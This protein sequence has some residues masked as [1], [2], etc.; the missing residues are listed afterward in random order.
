M[1]IVPARILIV[2]DNELNLKLF[3]D[4]LAAHGYTTEAVRDGRAA[5]WRALEYRPDLIL[6]DIQLPHVSGLDLIEAITA[7]PRLK[8]IPVM[9]IT[10]YAGRGDE[11]RI[12]AAG[13]SGYV[14]KPIT[15]GRFVEAIGALIRPVP[16]PVT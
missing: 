9:A 12:R 2:E 8:H 5:I 10:A 3:C 4:L 14:A 13:A 1:D 15:I 6:M 7:D 16:V 11:E